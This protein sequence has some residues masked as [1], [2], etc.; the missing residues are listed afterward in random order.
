[1]PSDDTEQNLIESVCRGNACELGLAQGQALRKKIHA[2]RE[3]LSQLETFRNRQPRWL[4]YV[5]Y[6]WLAERKSRRFV[7]AA[8]AGERIE[9]YQRMEGLAEGASL[10]FRAVC[11]MNALEPVLSSVVDSTASPGACSAVAVRGTRSAT[12]EPILVRN[13]DYL[14]LVQPFYTIR[15][16]RPEA[17]HRSLEFTMAPMVGAVDGMNDAGLCIAYDY[18]FPKDTPP[19]QS[20]PISIAIAEALQRC[21]SVG[22]AADWI[23][24]RPRWGGG[25]LMLIDAGGDMAS[26][27]LSN[28]RSFLR[29]P[30]D[31][32]DVLFHSNAFCDPGMRE[33]QIDWDAV[34]TE[35]AP[36]QLRGRRLHQSSEMRDARY[37]ELLRDSMPLDLD[38][39]A[40]LMADHG[41]DGEPSDDT[42]C[43]HGKYWQ[44]T[45][46]LQFLP[47]SRRL[48]VS[49]STACT[50]EYQTLQMES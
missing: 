34:Y 37:M 30:A 18:A 6:R 10:P 42:P 5:I 28:T 3:S 11:L 27:E 33:V 36:E 7:Q 14:P 45:A 2:A 17:G 44:T 24:S 20:P 21:E 22:E 41:P 48:R 12:G 39:L 29:R 26:L 38:G 50:A 47:R 35:R 23:S 15:D 25:L 19:H 9:A 1:M 46:C 43:L 31:G 32:E 16:V 8:F 40:R 13:F 49:Y 4:P